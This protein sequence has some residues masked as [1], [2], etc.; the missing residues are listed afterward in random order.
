MTGGALEIPKQQIISYL[1]SH[2][3]SDQAQQAQISYR[4]RST[5]RTTPIC[6]S[7]SA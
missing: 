3:Q 2:G 5:T 1:E 4:T 7:R 6:S